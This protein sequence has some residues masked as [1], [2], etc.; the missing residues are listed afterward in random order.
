MIEKDM[1]EKD[2]HNFV[3]QLEAKKKKKNK[4]DSHAHAAT[5]NFEWFI[6]CFCPR[7]LLK[8]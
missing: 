1:T 6:K 2:F 7:D 3:S 5:W 8:Q 4:H